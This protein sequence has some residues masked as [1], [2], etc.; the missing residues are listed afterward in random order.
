MDKQLDMLPNEKAIDKADVEHFLMPMIKHAILRSSN[1]VFI[2]KYV[3]DDGPY[4]VFVT[5]EKEKR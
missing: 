2:G 5:V 3:A 4:N 1:K